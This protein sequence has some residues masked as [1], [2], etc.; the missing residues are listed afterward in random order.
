MPMSIEFRKTEHF[1]SSQNEINPVF[2]DLLSS[3]DMAC[4]IYF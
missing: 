4:N 3:F 2:P 1:G